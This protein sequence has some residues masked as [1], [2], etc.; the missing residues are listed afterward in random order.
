MEL[1][2]GQPSREGEG[3]WERHG[4]TSAP[5]SLSHHM[6]VAGQCSHT[7]TSLDELS[8]GLRIHFG[9]VLDW[10]GTPPHMLMLWSGGTEPSDHWWG[11]AVDG[12]TRSMVSFKYVAWM[13]SYKGRD[14]S[15]CWWWFVTMLEDS[16]QHISGWE[17]RHQFW[18]LV[19]QAWAA[20]A[21]DGHSSSAEGSLCTRPGPGAFHTLLNLIAS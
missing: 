7:P 15:D 4:Y 13:E 3:T 19:P 5:P 1:T 11:Q 10:G 12:E 18:V 16:G 2:G 14:T 17:V 9:G 8:H 21:D 20:L 6:Q